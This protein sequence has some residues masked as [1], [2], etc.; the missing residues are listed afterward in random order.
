MASKTSESTTLDHQKKQPE[1]PEED[2]PLPQLFHNVKGRLLPLRAA[3]LGILKVVILALKAV[4]SA[5]LEGRHPERSEGSLYFVFVFACRRP[6]YRKKR[7][8]D[9]SNRQ[10]H[11][12][13]RSGETPHFARA[14]SY[15][16]PLCQ[17]KHRP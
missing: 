9:Q 13:L 1:T 11:R 14:F 7:H 2:A 4:I 10:S 3:E 8:L 12:L 16:L 5:P 6:H 15:T 17:P